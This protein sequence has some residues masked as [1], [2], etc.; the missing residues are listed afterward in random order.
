MTRGS[1]ES[2]AATGHA[3]HGRIDEAII[4]QA[5]EWMARLW[6]EQASDADARACSAWRAEHPDHERAWQRL[7]SLQGK[8]ETASRHSAGSSLLEAAAISRRRMLQLFSLLVAAGGGAYLARRTGF[9]QTALADYSSSIGEVNDFTLA[10]GS[11]VWLNTAS[12]IDVRYATG[13]RR[14]VLRQG[15]MLVET[16]MENEKPTR[17][18]LV[19]TQQ[20][21]LRA[22]GTR[23]LV[24]QHE[25]RSRVAVFEGAVEVQPQQANKRLTLQAGEGSHLTEHDVAAP[26]PVDESMAAWSRGRL[27]AEQMRL[28]D[29]VGELARYRHG[30]LRCATAAANLRVSGVFTLDDTD[31]A[32]ANLERALPVTV[33][34]RTPY[35][36]IVRARGDAG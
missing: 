13:E 36:V 9:W 10:D 11:R 16:G 25:H 17:R 4:R 15:D 5:A 3:E 35:W 21:Q 28:A 24:E 7:Q 8:F 29:F 14:I 23:F 2:V 20:G 22:L 31:R 34:Y 32:L 1:G 12:A 27:V 26:R 18:F 19:E 33:E 6:S 30:V